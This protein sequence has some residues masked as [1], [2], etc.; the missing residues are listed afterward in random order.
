MADPEGFKNI[1]MKFQNESGEKLGAKSI[2]QV[3]PGPKPAI[4]AKPTV[5]PV[6]ERLFQ[7]PLPKALSSPDLAISPKSDPLKAAG[8]SICSHQ[9]FS[10]QSNSRI[11]HKAS[12]NK[13]SVPLKKPIVPK[14]SVNSPHNK[15][16]TPSLHAPQM[17]RPA[18]Q[19]PTTPR[20]KLL[21]SE[22]VLGPRP[23][24]PARPPFVDLEKFQGPQDCG[25][26]V[27]MRSFL[28]SKHK[29]R[30]TTSQSQPNLTTC[31]PT[32][33]VRNSVGGSSELY[34]GTFPST[35]ERRKPLSSSLQHVV[36]T[37]TEAPEEVYDDVDVI[38]GRS[39]PPQ[40]SSQ[41]TLEENM[42]ITSWK[43]ETN[44]KKLQKQE[45]E[46]RRKFQFHGEIK[47]L[48]RMMV[49]PNAVIQ[50]PGYKD[51]AYTRG[52][53]LDV[54]QLTGSDKILC[55]NYEGKFGYVPRKAVL[56]IEKNIYSNG[57][58]DGIYDDTDLISN[59]LPAVPIKPRFQNGYVARLLQRKPCNKS[60]PPLTQRNNTITSR[61]EDKE[62][63]ELRKKFKIQGDIKVLTRMM[64]VPSAGNKRG[65]GKELS[66]SKGEILEVIQFTNNEKLL[67]RNNKGKYGYVKR[68]YVLQLE[69][70]IYDDVGISG[71]GI[72]QQRR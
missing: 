6:S 26:Y 17:K 19:Y 34:E 63:K 7:K 14:P 44:L 11:I 35:P 53:L 13:P 55:R 8:S 33:T 67:C 18:I 9:S 2:V 32:R 49:D 15:S 48:T 66:I 12:V 52:E 70:E 60:K 1:R 64:V 59:K 5:Q 71:S 50:K 43:N 58:D 36:I 69:K 41:S 29:T 57:N 56:N 37:E 54:I 65:G 21:P 4:P 72:I 51:L 45:E 42:L 24:K 46:F 39:K 40:F 16:G 38:L 68:R 61:Q 28:D 47:V 62:L 30:L 27:I 25:D 22:A 3:K 31:F 10:Y 23:K 20:L